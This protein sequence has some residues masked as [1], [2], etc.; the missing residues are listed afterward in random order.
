MDSGTEPVIPQAAPPA[1]PSP[2]PTGAPTGGGTSTSIRIGAVV[3]LVLLAGLVTW[4]VLDR[5]GGDDSTA[6][7][8][9]TSAVT[10]T[11]IGPVIV[12]AA[13]LSDQAAAVG[14]T[15]YWAGPIPGRRYEFRQTAGGRV[16][17]RYLS[18]G[19]KVGDPRLV[20]T[21]VGTYPV[22]NAYDALKSVSAGNE[23]EIPGGGIGSVSPTH[24]TSVHFAFP[25]VDYQGEVYDPSAAKAKQIAT[26]GA[27]QPIP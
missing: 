20:F 6:T 9:T 3:V 14:H 11:P 21:I 10:T 4:I 25:D 1:A 12:N 5:T 13:G 7:T 27:L 18:A 16:F 24:P 22:E 2:R 23:F 26:S 19:V 15:V 17:V 8:T